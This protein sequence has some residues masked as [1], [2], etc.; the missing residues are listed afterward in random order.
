MFSEVKAGNFTTLIYSILLNTGKRSLKMETMWKNSLK[1]A[2]DVRTVHVN[3]AV[4]A[5]TFY[6]K[7][8][9]KFMS[10]HIHCVFVILCFSHSPIHKTHFGCY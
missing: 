4:T 6:K 10:L 5:T 2:K 3:L 7:M 9:V 1:I 8:E